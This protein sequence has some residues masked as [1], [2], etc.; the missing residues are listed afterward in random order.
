M[1]AIDRSL[2]LDPLDWR[3]LPP[4][5]MAARAEAFLAAM[6]GRRTVRDFAARP[7]PRSLI[8][9]CLE[10]A[11]TAP[12]GANLQPWHFAVVADPDRKRRIREAAEVEERDF[13]AGKAGQAW[14]EAL[15]PLGTDPDKGF[16]EVAPWLIVIFAQRRSGLTPEESRKTYYF[17]ESVGIATGL[18]IAALHQSGLATLTHT[19]APMGFLNAICERPDT[20]KPYLILVTGYPAADAKTPR[21]ARIRK[22][23]SAITSWL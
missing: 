18:L 15:A 10:T 14:L 19:P 3:E 12:S 11:G 2:V 17:N 20:E 16:L 21:F 13:Y 7:V 5:D 8:E 23:L 9:T 22:P 6:R 1:T 4:Q